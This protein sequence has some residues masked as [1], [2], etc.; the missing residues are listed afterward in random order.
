MATWDW[1]HTTVIAG[2]STSVRVQGAP[3]SPVTVRL[4][5]DGVEVASGEVPS[6]PGTVSLAVPA[7]SQGK[8]FIIKVSCNGQ[9]DTKS[10]TVG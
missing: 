7:G 4:F 9:S 5:V 3:C 2:S 10:G 6:P 1:S 8:P